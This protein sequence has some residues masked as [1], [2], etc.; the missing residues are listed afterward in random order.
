MEKK[1]TLSVSI[2]NPELSDED[3]KK[4]SSKEQLL[5]IMEHLKS[6]DV[7]KYCVKVGLLVTDLS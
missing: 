2:L 7:I 6:L 5:T 1:L 3:I 4:M